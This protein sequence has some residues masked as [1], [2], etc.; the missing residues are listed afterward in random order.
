M[1]HYFLTSIILFFCL[2]INGQELDST[3]TLTP[4][5]REVYIQ[6]ALKLRSSNHF[7]EAVKTLDSILTFDAKD[8]GALL[9]KGDLLL[10]L[11]K[12]RDAVKTYKRLLPLDYEPVVTKI[13][14]SY[15]LFL[16]HKP[17]KALNMAKEAYELDKTNTVGI[18]NYF[19]AM[20]WN[21]KTDDAKRFLNENQSELDDSQKSILNARLYITKGQYKQGHVAYEQLLKKYD[22]KYF[23]QEFA[24]ALISKKEFSRA[25]KVIQEDSTAF[26]GLEYQLLIEKSREGNKKSLKSTTVYFEDIAE[27]VRFE[28]GFLWQQRES[29][30]YQFGLGAKSTTINTRETIKTVGQEI[31]LTCNQRWGIDLTGKTEAHLTQL[32]SSFSPTR[33]MLSGKQ[34]IMYQPN[35]RRMFGASLSSEILNFTA[36]LYSKGTRMTQL[37]YKTHIMFN[38]KNGFYSQGGAAIFSDNNNRAL[39]FGSLYHTVRTQPTIK[40]GINVSAVHFTNQSITD[41]FSP[42]AYLNSEVFAD[43][44]TAL[45]NTSRF[46]FYTLGAA[47]LQKINQNELEPIFRFEA[48]LGANFKNMNASLKYQ[49]SNVASESGTGYQYNWFTLDITVKM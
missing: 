42:K 48:K 37:G 14:L 33:V 40:T 16:S 19:N 25:E 39:F 9:F 21:A 5:E 38:A 29:K 28:Q 45:P 17:K 18:I 22:N 24:E 15:A 20:L 46:F 35:D 32:K 8:A 11:K 47:G 26:T 23:T 27:N 6:S 4:E 49:T 10:Q 12:N 36:D 13:N 2:A 44:M 41:Y 31:S 34:E 43:Y 1:K 7:D 30:K 3:K